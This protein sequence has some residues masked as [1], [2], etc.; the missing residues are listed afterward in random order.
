MYTKKQYLLTVALF[1]LVAVLVIMSISFTY[2]NSPI[3]STSDQILFQQASAQSAPNSISANTTN[4]S[5][6]ADSEQT[7]LRQG[8]VTSS[9]ARH[10]ETS[11]IA[12]ILP[13]RDDGKS[14]SG[15]LAFSASH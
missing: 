11:H 10:N 13:H 9:Q 5:N 12:V 2:N 3:K 1:S 7:I 4:N 14:Y 6:Y 8:L 15:V